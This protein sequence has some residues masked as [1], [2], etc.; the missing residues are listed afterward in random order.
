MILIW[1]P[2]SDTAQ[3]RSGSYF[4]AQ[5]LYLSLEQVRVLIVGKYVLLGQFIN[6]VTLE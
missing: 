3:G 1:S 4:Q 6:T 2:L 5:A